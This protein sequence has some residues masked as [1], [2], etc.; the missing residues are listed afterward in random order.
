MWKEDYAIQCIREMDYDFMVIDTD[1]R[2]ILA[3]RHID[4]KIILDDIVFGGYET[5]RD[6]FYL[7]EFPDVIVQVVKPHWEGKPCLHDEYGR[8]YDIQ[9]FMSWKPKKSKPGKKSKKDK[10]K[11]HK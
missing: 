11:K 5:V 4:G 2:V 6:V 10:K 8:V 9:G 3:K 7:P 1:G